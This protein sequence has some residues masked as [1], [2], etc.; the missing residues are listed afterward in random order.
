LTYVS[1]FFLQTYASIWH[2]FNYY[3]N[4]INAMSMLMV[5]PNHV[6]FRSLVLEL[7]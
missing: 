4:F 3:H 1:F 7:L 2:L 5:L 6:N